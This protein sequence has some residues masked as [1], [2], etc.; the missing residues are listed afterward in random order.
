MFAFERLSSLKA[1]ASPNTTPGKKFKA[2]WR[3]TVAWLPLGHDDADFH[4]GD[5]MGGHF[6]RWVSPL[7]LAN[8]KQ[9]TG[10]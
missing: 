3:L 10:M 6:E 9:R 2:V 8:V 7:E 4:D 1:R 5:I